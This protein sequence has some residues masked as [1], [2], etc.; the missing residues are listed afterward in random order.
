VWC[1]IAVAERPL[2]RLGL[3]WLRMG[4]VVIVA[5][6]GC[7]PNQVGRLLLHALPCSSRGTITPR[8]DLRIAEFSIAGGAAAGYTASAGLFGPSTKSF[9]AA[10]TMRETRTGHTATLLAGGEGPDR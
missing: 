3:C 10:G 6:I 8:R 5:S 1:T 7:L 9:R 2:F 4:L